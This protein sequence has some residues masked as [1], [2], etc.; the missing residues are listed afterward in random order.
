MVCLQAVNSSV[1]LLFS[2]MRFRAHFL[3][4]TLLVLSIISL[5]FGKEATDQQTGDEAKSLDAM[6]TTLVGQ[7]TQPARVESFEKMEEPSL[8]DWNTKVGEGLN[9][10]KR[11]LALRCALC[12]ARCRRRNR[13]GVCN[14][15]GA[16]QCRR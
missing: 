1:N 3:S 4:F 12:A 13:R 15:Q 6:M 5:S 16:C 8:G 10:Q 9:R 14:R 2:K 7:A 11:Q